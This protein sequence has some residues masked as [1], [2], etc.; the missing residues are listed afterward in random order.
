MTVKQ[1]RAFLAVAQTLSF[2]QA[3]ERMHLSQPALSLA[4]KG[5]EESLG[6]RLLIRTTRSVR[7]TPE[8]ES[9]VPLAK[10]LLAE[11]DNTEELMRQRFTLQLG[12]LTVAAMPSFASNLLPPAL[13]AF[14]SRHPRINVTVHDVINEQVIDMVRDRQVE[15]GIAFEPE[16]AGSLT[17]TTLFIDRFVAVVPPNS[18]LARH[19]RLSWEIL[20]THDFIALQRPSMVRRLLEQQIGKRG[21]RLPAAFESHQLATVGRMVANGL[22][23]SAVPSLCAKQMEELGARCLPL[24]DPAIERSVGML[25]HGELSAAALALRQVLMETLGHSARGGD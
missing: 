7:L 8:G 10:R 9:F 17:F 15:L 3:C 21:I 24:D 13:M 5:L 6:G 19:D 4:I 25:T 14:R 18:L 12:R 11:W 23:V 1:L 22:G 2:T 16:A 20:L